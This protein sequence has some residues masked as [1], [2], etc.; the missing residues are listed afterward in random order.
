MSTFRGHEA[1]DYLC[2]FLR[3]RRASHI[4]FLEAHEARRLSMFVETRELAI[5][6]FGGTSASGRPAIIYVHF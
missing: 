6:A 2:P 5:S 1:Q 4:Y 3:A